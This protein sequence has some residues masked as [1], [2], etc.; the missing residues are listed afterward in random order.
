MDLL[1]IPLSPPEAAYAS[2]QLPDGSR[3]KRCNGSSTDED[4]AIESD[5]FMESDL[6]AGG[7]Y[8]PELP[9]N[10]DTFERNG[11][12]LCL[13]SSDRSRVIQELDNLCSREGLAITSIDVL[14]CAYFYDETHTATPVVRVTVQ[15][16]NLPGG[17]WIF[18]SRMVHKFLIDKGIT[19][20]G[21]EI[22]GEALDKRFAAIS[23]LKSDRI[24]SLWNEVRDEI[25]DLGLEGVVIMGCFRAGRGETPE[26][27]PPAILIYVEPTVERDWKNFRDE[28]LAILQNFQ[29]NDPACKLDTVPLPSTSCTWTKSWLSLGLTCTHCVIPDGDILPTSEAQGF[30]YW[31]SNG[32]PVDDPEAEKSLL[33]NVPSIGYLKEAIRQLDS[34]I[35]FYKHQPTICAD[36]TACEKQRRKINE[37]GQTNQFHFGHVFAASGL[38]E[39]AATTDPSQL[40]I[41]DWSLIE[42]NNNR[43]VGENQIGVQ[44]PCNASRLRGLSF[45]TPKENRLLCKLGSKTGFTI[46]GY[47]LL[48]TAEIASRIVNGK[49]K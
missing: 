5:G 25:G 34:T 12:P 37:F 4:P 19:D 13:T 3:V 36:I 46:A 41:R 8:L 28:I 9:W 6:R 38:K 18:I 48:N 44:N 21:V 20:V 42:P 22:Y 23:A 7:P 2:G 11:H 39:V 1:I 29:L 10:T 17:G 15:G 35:N 32:V 14:D 43:P 27:C 31:E 49:E 45:E 26:E 40:S 24:S 47:S 30:H 33:M 16:E